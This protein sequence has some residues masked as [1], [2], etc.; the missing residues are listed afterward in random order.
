M[1]GIGKGLCLAGDLQGLLLLLILL[2]ITENQLPFER[3]CSRTQKKK[4]LSIQ[5]PPD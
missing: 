5:C 3:F 2:E 4:T 1:K